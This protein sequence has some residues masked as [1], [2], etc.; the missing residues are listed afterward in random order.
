[1]KC[2]MP[3]NGLV[4]TTDNDNELNIRSTEN[5]YWSFPISDCSGQYDDMKFICYSTHALRTPVRIQLY[6]M[7][8]LVA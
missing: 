8:V 3:A 5:I 2:P 1:M 4:T 6:E 7:S